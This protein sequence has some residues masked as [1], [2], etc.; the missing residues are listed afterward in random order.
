MDQVSQL[1][2]L[3][4]LLSFLQS[5]LA[6]FLGSSSVCL[7]AGDHVK[8]RYFFSS[9]VVNLLHQGQINHFLTS[10]VWFLIKQTRLSTILNT[11]V[12]IKVFVNKGIICPSILIGF[13]P[14][15]VC[16]MW[17]SW[18]VCHNWN[19][20]FLHTALLASCYMLLSLWFKDR[21]SPILFKWSKKELIV[22]RSNASLVSSE[23]EKPSNEAV[24]EYMEGRKKYEDQRK[25][26]LKKGS[27]REQ[28]VILLSVLSIMTAYKTQSGIRVLV[29][30]LYCISEVMSDVFGR[31]W[32]SSIVSSPSCLRPSLLML[33]R[34]TWRSWQRTMTKDGEPDTF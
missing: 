21:H 24:A 8:Q 7:S 4:F 11:L 16:C 17:C 3:N 5:C 2:K 12:D 13:F 22:M 9:N 28:Q 20:V 32:N 15:L 19:L 30:R 10:T 34:R 29:S 27:V 18:N 26:K 23:E 33:Q 25:Q 6:C 14:F 31:H 1:D